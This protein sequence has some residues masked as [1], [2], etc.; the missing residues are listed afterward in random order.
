MINDIIITCKGD[1]KEIKRIASFID[2]KI[3]DAS[4][5]V[6]GK[7]ILIDETNEILSVS[8]FEK[9]C[10]AIAEMSPQ[11]EYSLSATG[12]DKGYLYAI[13]ITYDGFF[14]KSCDSD[15]YRIID[16]S[17]INT[18]EEFM[19]S[20]IKVKL[21]EKKFDDIKTGK[22]NIYNIRPD[23]KKPKYSLKIVM[24][25]ERIVFPKRKQI[26]EPINELGEIHTF[27][28]RTQWGTSIG[29]EMCVDVNG[30]KYYFFARHYDTMK[31]LQ[32]FV[33]NESV[34]FFYE[35]IGSDAEKTEEEKRQ[36]E[37]IMALAIEEYDTGFEMNPIVE[38]SGMFSQQLLALY[39][40]ISEKAEQSETRVTISLKVANKK[41]DNKG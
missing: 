6:K 26:I 15:Y 24:N 11:T 19:N 10:I 2:G 37:R 33:T 1:A 3:L 7:K 21:T 27:L 38:Y 29:A 4:A 12:E 30:E 32:F 39:K 17:G 41:A 16:L 40:A 9:I 5:V 23:A 14:V 25:D 31:S 22:G 28:E 35:K 36:Y 8:D 34:R 20:G 13:Q 18:Y